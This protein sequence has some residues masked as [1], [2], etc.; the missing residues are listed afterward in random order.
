MGVTKSEQFSTQHNHIS[1]LAKA[2]SHPAR[3]AILDYLIKQNGC[4]CND[5]VEELPLSQPTVSQHLKELRT[6]G[7]IKGEIDGNAIC[8]AVDEKSVMKLKKYIDKITEK[9][10]RNK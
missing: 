2:I 7:L 5:I 4:I 10:A 3:V 1:I 8:Y 9:L 6:A